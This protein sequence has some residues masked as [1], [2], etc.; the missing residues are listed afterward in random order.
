MDKASPIL[1]AREEV[2]SGDGE[3]VNENVRRLWGEAESYLV[4]FGIKNRADKKRQVR[5]RS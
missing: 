2:G 5:I 3:V 4:E 1:V